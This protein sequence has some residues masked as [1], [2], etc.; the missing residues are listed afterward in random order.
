[1]LEL[2]TY[3][4]SLLLLAMAKLLVLVAVIQQNVSSFLLPAQNSPFDPCLVHCL[5][6][7]CALCQE[8]REMKVRLPPTESV[9]EP[10]QPPAEQEMA[11]STKTSEDPQSQV[12]TAAPL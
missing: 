3:D 5:L 7:Q 2:I 8:H 9:S 1:M 4:G 10:L 11:T 6:H 12:T